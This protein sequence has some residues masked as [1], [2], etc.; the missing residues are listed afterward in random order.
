[1]FA[2]PESSEPYP[3]VQACE[4]GGVSAVSRG[5]SQIVVSLMDGGCGH[6]E[7]SELVSGRLAFA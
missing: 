5:K 7:L 2:A 6:R 1:L 3:Q 4:L